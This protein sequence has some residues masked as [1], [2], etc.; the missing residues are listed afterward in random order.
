MKQFQLTVSSNTP[1]LE[2]SLQGHP[3]GVTDLP[4]EVRQMIYNYMLPEEVYCHISN[5][6]LVVGS[7]YY[8]RTEQRRSCVAL[9]STCRLIKNELHLPL[10]AKLRF[11]AFKPQ[12]LQ[13]FTDRYSHLAPGIR[14]AVLHFGLSLK[15]DPGSVET[16]ERRTSIACLRKMSSLQNL[17]VFGVS[18][19][20]TIQCNGDEYILTNTLCSNGLAKLRLL[21]RHMPNMVP[22]SLADR[23]S[24]GS[25]TYDLQVLFKA[26]PFAQQ[27]CDVPIDLAT[28]AAIVKEAIRNCRYEEWRIGIQAHPHPMVHNVDVLF[29]G[30]HIDNIVCGVAVL[31]LMVLCVALYLRTDD[32]QEQA[33]DVGLKEEID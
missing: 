31:L 19:Y 5:K 11:V 21:Q 32:Q 7:E 10:Y 24:E 8:G 26:R 17:M 4:G 33:R 25:P 6:G 12:H 13:E 22:F 3:L 9:L 23:M 15:A 14:R 16:L 30:L 27:Q 20:T 28:E 2:N 18:R 29:D 1:A